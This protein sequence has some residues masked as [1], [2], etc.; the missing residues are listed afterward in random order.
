MYYLRVRGQIGW[1]VVVV[2]G[3]EVK[4]NPGFI[5]LIFFW[6]T[7]QVKHGGRVR[8][9]DDDEDEDDDDKAL[10]VRPSKVS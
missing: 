9:D 10:F 1:F 3:Q 6:L 2:V 8:D 5:Y 7:K 4:K